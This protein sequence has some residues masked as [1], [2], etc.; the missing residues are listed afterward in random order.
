MAGDSAGAKFAA[1]WGAARGQG[2]GLRGPRRPMTRAVPRSLA[3]AAN[4]IAGHWQA[5]AAG[6]GESAPRPTAPMR[7]GRPGRR[8]VPRSHA[9]LSQRALW[10]VNARFGA[11][12]AR[13]GSVNARFGGGDAVASNERCCARPRRLGRSVPRVAACASAGGHRRR[14]DAD[15]RR[16]L[17]LRLRRRGRRGTGRARRPRPAL[18]RRGAAAGPWERTRPRRRTLARRGE[19]R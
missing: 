4:V 15:Q 11:V 18:R 16:A 2:S 1:R 8:G 13:S 5:P 3:C 14:R 12:R 6:P 10:A 17:L 7:R 19:R 9:P